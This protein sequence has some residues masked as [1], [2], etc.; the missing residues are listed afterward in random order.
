MFQ[1]T[2][3]KILGKAI[4]VV[5]LVEPLWVH[6]ASHLQDLEVSFKL[7]RELRG[8]HIKPTISCG[9]LPLCLVNTTTSVISK[10]F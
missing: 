2:D 8:F 4:S 5:L 6:G 7:L 9:F 1:R 10:A 3:L